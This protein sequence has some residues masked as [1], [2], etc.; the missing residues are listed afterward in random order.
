MEP[1]GTQA[2]S[3]RGCRLYYSRLPYRCKERTHLQA[4]ILP[5]RKVESKASE[6]LPWIDLDRPVA[7]TKAFERR[8]VT[9]I[10]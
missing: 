7:R 6:Y 1:S 3:R 8:K 10:E 2:L 5:R 9:T 4:S